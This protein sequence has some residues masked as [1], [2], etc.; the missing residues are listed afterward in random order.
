MD[1]RSFLTSAV[2]AATLPKLLPPVAA[3]LATALAP[4][5]AAAQAADVPHALGT[6]WRA[7]RDA[8]LDFSGRVID[9]P[10]FNAS[11]SEGQGYGMVLAAFFGD[12]A[13]FERMADWTQTHLAIRP[14]NL[15]AWRWRPDLPERVPDLNNASDGDLFYAWALLL[16]SRRFGREDWRRRAAAIVDDLETRCTAERPDRPGTLVLL[17]AARYFAFADRI[18]VNPS[19]IMPRAMSDLAEAFGASRMAQVSRSGLELVTELAGRG[20]VPDWV[21][22]T[23]NGVGPAP[24]FS[25]HFGY[26]SVRVPLFLLWSGESQHQAVARAGSAIGRAPDGQAAIVIETQTGRAI[27]YSPDP[28]YRAIGALSRCVTD[29]QIG[30]A[31][32]PFAVTQPYYPA[33]LHLFTLLAQSENFPSCRPI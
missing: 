11:H 5:R 31:I 24:G 12:R 17:P 10:Q 22:I 29:G 15:L 23:A 19:Y 32:P 25:E 2:S 7:W 30:A 4:A 16:G 28:G 1:R 20:L 13:A 9:G 21:Q 26:E 8:Y 3:S 33:T 14:D 6:L 18:L 27:E